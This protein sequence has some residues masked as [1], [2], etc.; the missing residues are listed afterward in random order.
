MLHE[1][2]GRVVEGEAWVLDWEVLPR[3][4]YTT[5]FPTSLAFTEWDRRP[6]EGALR[7]L[8]EP[9]ITILLVHPEQSH[10]RDSTAKARILPHD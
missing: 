1:A 7:R 6:H 4:T 3:L 8:S 2:G 5:C 10:F 9:T